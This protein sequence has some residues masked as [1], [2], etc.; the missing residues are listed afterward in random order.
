MPSCPVHV[1]LI[2]CIIAFL[3]EINGDGDLSFI[4]GRLQA[5]EDILNT[6]SCFISLNLWEQEQWRVFVLFAIC[7]WIVQFTA[8]AAVWT[9]L[10]C[11]FNVQRWA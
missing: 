7:V 8:G 5:C 9:V 11:R 1:S 10:S 3:N 4:N 2:A 6:F